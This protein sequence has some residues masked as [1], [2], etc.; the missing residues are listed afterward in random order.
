MENELRKRRKRKDSS[1]MIS[2][3]IA[4]VCLNLK[5]GWH[6][7]AVHAKAPGLGAAQSGETLCSL[8]F[9]HGKQGKQPSRLACVF[10]LCVV[11]ELDIKKIP[12]RS[13]II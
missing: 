8:T 6:D 4:K 5:P 9:K 3:G 12:V 10:M 7:P 13:R 2:S 11:C 1:C